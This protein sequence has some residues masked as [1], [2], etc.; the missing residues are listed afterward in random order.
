VEFLPFLEPSDEC[1]DRFGDVSV[2]GE[3]GDLAAGVGFAGLLLLFGAFGFSRLDAGKGFRLFEGF[4]GGSGLRLDL[5]ELV[6]ET[7]LLQLHVPG[8]CSF[9]ASCPEGGQE[10]WPVGHEGVGLVGCFRLS[11]GDVLGEGGD[12]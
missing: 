8:V 5:G 10:A 6:L 2:A 12:G 9:L 3:R 1:R 4:G 7:V 11:D